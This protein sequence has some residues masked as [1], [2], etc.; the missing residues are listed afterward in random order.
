MAVEVLQ[1]ED[2]SGGRKN[3]ERKG[4]GSAIRRRGA[5]RGDHKQWQINITALNLC[6]IFFIT[7]NY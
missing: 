2:I 3:E 5:Y 7:C 1:N 4:A 6:F